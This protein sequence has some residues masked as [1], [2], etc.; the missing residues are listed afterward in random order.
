[1][2]RKLKPRHVDE[3]VAAARAL[4][5]EVGSLKFAAPVTHV[6]NPLDYAWSGHE[7]YIRAFGAGPKIGRAHV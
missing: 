6:Y 1:M 7:A 5:D 4:G 3:L 2:S